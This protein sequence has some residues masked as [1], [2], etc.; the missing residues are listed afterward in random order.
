MS[1]GIEKYIKQTTEDRRMWTKN[2]LEILTAV[3]G[4]RVTFWKYLYCDRII[5]EDRKRLT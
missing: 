3:I 1:G 5:S 4:C 2:V